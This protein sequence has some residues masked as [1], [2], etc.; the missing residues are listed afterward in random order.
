MRCKIDNDK[1]EH[2]GKVY[3]VHSLKSRPKSTA[4]ELKLEDDDG[5]ITTQVVASHQIEWIDDGN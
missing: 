2:A 3:F 5:N 1:W 4:V